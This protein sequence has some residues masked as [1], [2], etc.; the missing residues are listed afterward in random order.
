MNKRFAIPKLRWL[1]AGL[2]LGVTLINY[3]DRLTVSVLVGEIRQGLNL[4]EADYSQIVSIFLAAYAVMYGVS[5]YCLDRLGTRNGM[6]VFVCFWSVFQI[7][8]GLAMGKWSFAACRFGLGLA[9]PVCFP[10][11]I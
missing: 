6:V 10:A 11:A 7:L 1:I 2:L 8:H 3:T 9:E 4:S 5:G